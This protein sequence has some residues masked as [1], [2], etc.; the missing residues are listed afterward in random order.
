MKRYRGYG[1]G[2]TAAALELKREMCVMETSWSETQKSYIF[3]NHL[4]YTKQ[5]SHANSK[6]LCGTCECVKKT[7]PDSSKFP[8]KRA[9]L[10]AP[11]NFCASGFS[12]ISG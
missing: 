6:T 2:F 1:G 3:S 7:G 5:L 8:T 10:R 9:Q 12:F 11:Q 4:T